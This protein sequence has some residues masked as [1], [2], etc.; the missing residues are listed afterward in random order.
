MEAPT[1]LRAGCALCGGA[2]REATLAFAHRRGGEN[3]SLEIALCGSCGDRLE[4]HLKR[5]IPKRLFDRTPAA[6]GGARSRH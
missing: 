4:K 5:A 2:S 3:V 1:S 6:P